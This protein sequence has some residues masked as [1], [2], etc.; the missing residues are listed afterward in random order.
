MNRQLRKVDARHPRGGVFSARWRP[1]EVPEDL[2]DSAPREGRVRLPAEIAWSGQPDYDLGDRQQLRRVYEQV[3]REGTADEIRAY[4]RA[5]TLCELWD[6]LY[7]PAYVRSAWEPWVAACRG[8]RD[9][10]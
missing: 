2:D 7:L 9:C 6:E 4:V 3:L 10:R 5:S 8:G 1:V